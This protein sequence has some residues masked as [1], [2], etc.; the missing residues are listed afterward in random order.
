[1]RERPS[2]WRK[3]RPREKSAVKARQLI[4]PTLKRPRRG[5]EWKIKRLAAERDYCEICNIFLH[6]QLA[7][8]VVRTHPPIHHIIPESFLCRFAPGADPHVPVNLMCV[9][10]SCHGNVLS[11]EA[12][13]F[14]GD[15][16]GFLQ[17][18]RERNWPMDRILAA[19]AFYGL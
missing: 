16:L 4:L 14:R 10:K 8:K 13:L 7:D 17:G 1:M 18:L 5:K 2:W 15:K 19:L 3:R 12:K 6:I 9:C 11:I